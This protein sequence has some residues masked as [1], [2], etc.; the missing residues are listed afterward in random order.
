MGKQATRRG[1]STVATKTSSRARTRRR[2]WRWSHGLALSVPLLLV[3]ALLWAATLGRL[4]TSAAA[5]NGI[6]F[7]DYYTV[8]HALGKPPV[9]EGSSIYTTEVQ[10]ALGAK[11]LR[12]ARASGTQRQKY[13]ANFFNVLQ[14]TSSPYT[15]SVWRLVSWLPYDTGFKLF[16]A[17]SLIV[18]VVSLF[19]LGNL[20]RH[21]PAFS[22]VLGLALCFSSM[23]LDSDIRV[24]NV[25]RVLVGGLTLYLW[26]QARAHAAWLTHHRH[27]KLWH[28]AIGA[29]M[30]CLV[31]FKP[32][33]GSLL[34]M[35]WLGTLCSGRVR[36]SLQQVAGAAAAS[37]L[38]VAVGAP[39]FGGPA[40]WLRWLRSITTTLSDGVTT[41]AQGNYVP[42]RV[43]ELFWP[44]VPWRIYGTAFAVCVIAATVLRLSTVPAARERSVADHVRQQ[45]LLLGLGFTFTICTSRLAWLHWQLLLTPCIVALAPFKLPRGPWQLTAAVA[46]VCGIALLSPDA[47]RPII[48]IQPP[49]GSALVVVTADAVFA[50]LCFLGVWH[51]VGARSSVVD[52]AVHRS[53]VT[54]GAQVSEPK[55][56]GRGRGSRGRRNRDVRPDGAS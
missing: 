24:C 28:F 50:C 9:L 23:P 8:S 52:P 41:V 47:L 27:A 36:Q 34:A 40:A 18:F 31:V 51:T 56:A 1:D 49:V 25:N 54:K 17:F 4:W 30:L 44:T 45:A 26:L 43:L 21:A 48:T 53:V 6:D 33:V 7:Y 22:A 11:E 42:A 10:R 46:W 3:A 35:G 13:A 12:E 20:L 29:T 2:A 16:Q 19:V 55:V 32:V 37:V 5:A 38:V 39:Q 14:P 15:Y